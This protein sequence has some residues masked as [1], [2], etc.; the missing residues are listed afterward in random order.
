[1][2]RNIFPSFEFYYPP[3]H[4]RPPLLSTRHTPGCRWIA[5]VGSPRCCRGRGARASASAS[6]SRSPG[7]PEADGD[8]QEAGGRAGDSRGAA[9]TRTWEHG[10][11]RARYGEGDWYWQPAPC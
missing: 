8:G 11:I 10:V 9:Q 2:R 5:G 7:A 4:D 1:M 3:D 6:C